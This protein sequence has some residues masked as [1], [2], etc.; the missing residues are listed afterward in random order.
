MHQLAFCGEFLSG[1]EG[2]Q[3]GF[4]I[5]VRFA[6]GA[7]QPCGNQPQDI[8]LPH[9]E[10]GKV[11]VC[12]AFRGQQCMVVGKYDF[13]DLSHLEGTFKVHTLQ[14]ILLEGKVD[15]S[16]IAPHGCKRITVYDSAESG[17]SSRSS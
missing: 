7:E 10:C 9:R 16:E 17:R 6:Y 4:C 3:G 11:C 13:T 2:G 5:A 12:H 8:P 15:L 1:A 14:G